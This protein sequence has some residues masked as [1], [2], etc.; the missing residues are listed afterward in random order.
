MADTGG[1]FP[2]AGEGYGDDSTI[3]GNIAGAAGTSTGGLVLSRGALIAIIVVVVVV[4]LFG[5]ASS[6]LFFIAKKR[7]WTVKETL[8]RSARK[9]VTALTPRRSEFPKSVKEST[10]GGRSRLDD[11]PP[12]P[13]IKPEYLDLEKGLDKPKKKRA[14]FG[15]K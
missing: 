10:S 9:V 7:E 2:L 3:D 4:A 1:H 12:T 14:N 8:R 5:I 13:R 11:V 15:R 6:I